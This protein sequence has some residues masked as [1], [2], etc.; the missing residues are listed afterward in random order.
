MVPHLNRLALVFVLVVFSWCIVSGVAFF[1]LLLPVNAAHADRE[2]IVVHRGMSFEQIAMMLKEKNLI[3]SV[4]AF[5][6]YALLTFKAHRLQ[7]GDYTFSQDMSVPRI[8]ALLGNNLG[9]E[10][11]VV[12]PEGVTLRDID[13]IL[14]AH[15]VIQ[16]GALIA[17]DATGPR[18]LEGFLFPDT[19][20]FAVDSSVDAVVAKFTQTFNEKGL[21]AIQKS[22]RGVY[23]SLTLASL[24]EREVPDGGDRA[25]VAGVLIKRL[26]AGWPLQV[27]A[28]FC[29]EQIGKCSLTPADFKRN[30]PYNTYLY[31]GL[32]PTPIGNPGQSALRAAEA[33]K[34]S[35]YW[36]YLSDPK[37][38]KT[39]F[40]VTLEE[41][42]ANKQKY[43]E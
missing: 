19:Y 3:R 9:H 10:A 40:A 11:E 20:R 8:V 42:V 21:P 27:D 31:K 6:V 2:D 33:P 32:P 35:P 26:E 24:I 5:E 30:S 23:E 1:F 13:G 34:A 37:T 22:V 7:S 38:G 25:I 28:A 15:G 43:L 29:Y 4:S 36:Y 39:I 18:S 41:Q 14:A 17:Y 12:I 16:P